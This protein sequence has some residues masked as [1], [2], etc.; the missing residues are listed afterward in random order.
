MPKVDLSIIIPARSEMF[1]SRTVDD[2]LEN[3]R[4]NTEII[5]G[6]DGNW[7]DPPIQDHPKVHIIHHSKSIGQRAITNEGVKLSRAKYIMKVDAHCSFDEGFDI[8]MISEMQDDWTMVP[9]M[10]NFHVFNW[11]CKKCGEIRYQ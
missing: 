1:L 7:S 8:K 9:V 4:G 2:A 3:I 11:I 5:V 10:R 6:C